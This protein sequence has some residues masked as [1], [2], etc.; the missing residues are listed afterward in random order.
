MSICPPQVFQKKDKASYEREL[1][2]Y[3]LRN[4]KHPNVLL[5][6]DTVVYPEELQ[7]IFEFHENGSLHDLLNKQAISLKQFCDIAVSA[8]RGEFSLDLLLYTIVYMYEHVHVAMVRIHTC[9]LYHYEPAWN[10]MSH[11]V[12]RTR[13]LAGVHFQY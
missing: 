13:R 6:V 1:S 5:F 3:K 8:S 4:F 9:M 2:I 10:S 7:M 12:L 11:Y